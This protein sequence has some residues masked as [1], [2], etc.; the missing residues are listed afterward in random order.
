MDIE[1]G[2]ASGKGGDALADAARR[3][4]AELPATQAASAAALAE[5]EPLMSNLFQYPLQGSTWRPLVRN[6]GRSD[7]Q[8]PFRGRDS[9]RQ[10]RP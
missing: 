2:A 9:W 6:P 3:D 4:D 8:P 10:A 5:A 7:R 1:V